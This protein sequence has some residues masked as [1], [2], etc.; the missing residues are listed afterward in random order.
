MSDPITIVSLDGH[1]Q[2]PESEWEH[3]LEAKYHEYL[4]RLSGDNVRWIDVMGRLMVD[5]IN[6]QVD[7]FD[8]DGVYRADG[9]DGIWNLDTRLRE[10]DREGIAAEV[11]YNGEPRMTALFFQQTNGRYPDEVCEA[12]AC[13]VVTP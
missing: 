2:M 12:G 1:P 5:R 13:K 9:L 3:F 10:M 7:V 4:P 6:E 11:V 8:L